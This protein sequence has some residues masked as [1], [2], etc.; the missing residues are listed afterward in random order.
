M[1]AVAVVAVGFTSCSDEDFTAS[2]F[3]T[4]PSI[5]YLDKSSFTFPLDT[6]C[7]KEFL[8]PYNL[9]F[10]YRMEDKASDM[11]KNLTPAD[12]D[13]SV[14]LAVLTK[15]LW[16]DI[17]KDLAGEEFLKENSPRIIHVVGSKNLNPSQGTEVLGDASSG[18]KINLYN[19]NN[20]DAS[21]INVMNE[22]FF[23]TMH[24]E[25]AHILDQTH[26]HPTA[27]NIVTQGSYDASGWNEASDSLKASVGFVSP[28]ASSSTDEDWAETM[29]VYITA[30]SVT[31]KNLLSSASYEWEEVD[32]ANLDAYTAMLTPNCNKDTIGYFKNAESGDYKIVRRKCVRDANDHVVLGD[33]GQPQWIHESGVDGNL[34]IKTKVSYVRTYLLEYY[35]IDIDDLRKE[36]QD[37]MY[38]RGSDGKYIFNGYVVDMTTNTKNTGANVPQLENN[39]TAVQ[40]SGKTLIEELREW[41]NQYKALQQ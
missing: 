41:V 25:F 22:Y 6:F 8:E 34:L 37:R 10:I 5:D 26:V 1:A 18:V 30:D 39:L 32:V 23:K 27:F 11:N 33:D 28:Y 2:I 15:Y 3:N 19:A 40:A 38:V 21:N 14:D 36:V 12:Y 20:L 9:K 7:K 13:K 24:H 35:G 17:Y 31:W 16:Y 29:A 4:D